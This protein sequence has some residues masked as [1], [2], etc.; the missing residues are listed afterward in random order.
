MTGYPNGLGGVLVLEP[1]ETGLNAT[2]FFDGVEI[3]IETEDGERHEWSREHIAATPFD[4]CTTELHLDGARLFFRADDP[5]EFSDRLA[6]Y[7]SAPTKKKRGRSHGA[8]TEKPEQPTT[9]VEIDLRAPKHEPVDHEP[10]S[11]AEQA[12]SERRGRWR[13]KPHEHSWITGPA[14]G[15]ILRRRCH[16]CGAVSISDTRLELEGDP[17]AVFTR[18]R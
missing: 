16:E 17:A 6:G 5:L 15:G 11:L 18:R 2:V 10:E 7:L 1:G 4:T 3:A 8:S 13:R 12:P 9:A 14:G